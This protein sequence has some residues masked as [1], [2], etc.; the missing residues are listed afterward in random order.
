[1][2]SIERTAYPRFKRSP[3]ARELETLYTPT[4]DELSFARANARKAQP[5]FGLLLLLKSFQRLGYFPAVDDIPPSIVQHIRAAASIDA[6]SSPSYEEQRTLYRHHQ[7]I[8]ERLG[9]SAWGEDGL[10]VAG[11]AMASAAEV[12]DN[13]ADLINVAIEELVHQRIELPAFSTLD[14]LS[15]R[16]RT[17][18]NGRFFETVM[19]RLS[20]AERG[21]LDALLEVGD[22]PQKKACSSPSSSFP[23]VP[24]WSIYRI[25]STTSL[26]CRP[27]S[28]PIIAWRAFPTPRSSISRPRPRRSMPRS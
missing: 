5:R 24:R 12:M 21:Q 10:R 25:C 20:E 8:R 2:A 6:E 15:R 13:P 28:A 26:S 17:L 19:A 27:P 7:M 3:S 14:R 16:V 4:A 23:S 22:S 9:V 18:V 1:M 11:E